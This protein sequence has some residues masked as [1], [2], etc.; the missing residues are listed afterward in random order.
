MK[1]KYLKSSS[2]N[3]YH[4]RLGNI[5]SKSIGLHI[6]RHLPWRSFFA[7][8]CA[9]QKQSVQLF[10]SGGIQRTRTLSSYM[11]CIILLAIRKQKSEDKATSSDPLWTGSILANLAV[12]PC[13]FFISEYTQS[14][15]GWG[16]LRM[17][18]SESKSDFVSDKYRGT[19]GAL[20]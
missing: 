7:G 5:L 13:M 11:V 18:Y 20:F 6:P 17:L 9:G 8:E 3:F 4:W 14:L 10:L 2:L 19:W 1:L 12:C 15:S 16:F